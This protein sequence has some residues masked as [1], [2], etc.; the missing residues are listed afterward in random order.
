MKSFI[1][2][3]PFLPVVC[4]FGHS[5]SPVEVNQPYPG[6]LAYAPTPIPDRIVLTWTG[7][8]ATTQAV[9]WRSAPMERKA[10]AQIQEATPGPL[11][12]VKDRIP[13]TTR[14]LE[15][16]TGK[17]DY[18]T[19]E[20]AGLSADTLYAY[21][22]GDG[23]NWSEWHHF[24]TAS[25]EAKPFSFIYVGDAQNNIRKH[26][27]RLIREAIREAPRAAFTLHAGD[28]VNNAN[29]DIQWG[30]WFAA[31]GWVNA[32]IPVVATP[33]NHEYNAE[34]RIDE[35]GNKVRLLSRHWQP[36]FAFPENGP[37]GLEESSYYFDYQGARFVILNSNEQLEKQAEWLREV[38]SVDPQ[39]WTLLAF[40][41][42]VFYP[43][44]NR[45]KNEGQ[46]ANRRQ[47]LWKPILDEFNVDLVL[48][49]H[50]HTYARSGIENV[51]VGYPAT[52]DVENGTVYVV[53]V[54]G[55]KMYKVGEADW[56]VRS[57]QDTQLYQ[58][59]RIEGDTLI[60]EARSADNQ[61]FDSFKLHKRDGAPNLLEERLPSTG[62]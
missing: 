57:I 10:V 9:T 28:L 24:K 48:T 60:Y 44:K 23:I 36:Q 56:M 6:V 26:W 43:S 33:G 62:R 25:S 17:S 52:Q 41:H 20:F 4:L 12:D 16:E 51:P 40:H 45:L 37:E 61:L 53:S 2:L 38:L 13:A 34:T 22:V 19:V 39:K 18:H 15:A 58:V 1:T 55:P 35:A 11:P 31:P 32:S 27:S 8:P 42:P 59:I 49:G 3:L 50:D 5:P 21:R 46:R 47:I 14:S 29:N 30:E 54:S 7:D